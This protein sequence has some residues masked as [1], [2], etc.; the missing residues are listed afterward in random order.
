MYGLRTL[1]ILCLWI[2][3]P[4]R[5]FNPS[6]LIPVLWLMV[7]VDLF[8][9]CFVPWTEETQEVL[10]RK[11]VIAKRTVVQIMRGLMRAENC[12]SWLDWQGFGA[13]CAKDV[14][15]IFIF[16]ALILDFCGSCEGTFSPLWRNLCLLVLVIWFWLHV[17]LRWVWQHFFN[18]GVLD[19]D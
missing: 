4:V 14:S 18:L 7:W 13:M 12:A 17:L 15:M 9:T 8:D 16:E 5:V 1:E 10:R 19:K 11:A 6:G 3:F 2:R